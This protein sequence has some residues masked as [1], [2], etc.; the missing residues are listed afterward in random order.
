M[1]MVGRTLAFVVTCGVLANGCNDVSRSPPL[2]SPA[3][4]VVEVP[5]G[6]TDRPV[7]KE[8]AIQIASLFVASK[9]E[10]LHR[11]E[12]I[13]VDMEMNP[14]TNRQ[15]WSLMYAK[16]SQIPGDFFVVY[17]DAISGAATFV[18]GA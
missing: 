11:Y 17:V 3:P 6:V 16:K 2:G 4:S 1:S 9:G 7:N 12:L 14:V 8:V 10:N 13:H 18:G 5:F 15:R